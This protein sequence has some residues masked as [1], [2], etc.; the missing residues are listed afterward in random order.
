MTL[1]QEIQSEY[2][3]KSFKLFIT[4]FEQLLKESR[5]NLDV[6]EG[7]KIYKLQGEIQILKRLLKITVSRES[8]YSDCDGGFGEN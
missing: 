6:A 2:H 7:N 3:S 4:Y 1:I 8:K 5:E